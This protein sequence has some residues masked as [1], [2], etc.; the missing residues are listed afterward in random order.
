MGTLP[1]CPCP[2]LVDTSTMERGTLRLRQRPSPTTD[3]PVSDMPDLDTPD[4]DTPD[5]DTLVWDTLASDTLVSDTLASDTLVWE[6]TMERGRPRLSLR[7]RLN[8]TTDTLGSD[9]PDLDTL[10][11]DTLV[12][13][14]PGSTPAMSVSAPTTW[15]LPCL[16]RK[17][18]NTEKFREVRNFCWKQFEI[19]CL[20]YIVVKC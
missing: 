5:S 20:K 14:T 7:L 17:L 10:D 16:A 8:L 9:M 11:S 18:R 2:V 6:S 12:W 15:E 3:T 1:T 13:D 4:L 19:K